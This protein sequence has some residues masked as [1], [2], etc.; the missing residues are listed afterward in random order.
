MDS[1]SFEKIAP[2]LKDPLVLAGFALLLFFGIARTLIKSGL[3]R[4]VTRDGS[5]KILVRI[6]TYGFVLSI[7]VIALG[8]GLKYRALDEAE[9]RNVVQLLG[10]EFSANLDGVE[11]LRRNTTTLLSLVQ[12]TSSALRNKNI[13]ALSTLFPNQNIERA[14]ALSA[15][16][17]A[18][19]ALTELFDKRIDQNKSEMAK[20]DAAAKA[21]RGSIDRTKQTI[22]SMADPKRQRFVIREDVWLANLATLRQVFEAGVPE[23]QASYAEM[24]KIRSD[25]DVI[26][27]SVTAYFDALYKLFDKNPGVTIDSLTSALAQERQTIGLL[28]TYGLTLTDSME[29]LKRLQSHLSEIEQRK[30]SG[31]R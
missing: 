5:Y 17:L 22:D 11:S 25:Y 8:F 9:Q 31:T 14:A 2:Y 15:K 16:D 12:A 3:L 19:Q 24:R 13:P 28:A 26:C 4:Q 29:K 20:G 27:A 6:L 1:F 10:R 7:L 30:L 23:L 18:L 21:I